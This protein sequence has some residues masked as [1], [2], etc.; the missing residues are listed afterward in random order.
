MSINELYFGIR[1]S[2][3]QFDPEIKEIE[4]NYSEER[5]GDIK[6]SIADISMAKELLG[7]NP[8]YDCHKGLHEA[9][10]WYWKSLS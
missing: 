10:D 3:S 1:D 5:A 8:E 6:H 4:P 7:Y 2:L 9:I